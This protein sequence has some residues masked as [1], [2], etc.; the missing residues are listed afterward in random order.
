MFTADKYEC[1]DSQI[2]DEYRNEA[3]VIVQSISGPI[4]DN[5][6]VPYFKL[7]KGTILGD[8]ILLK[9]ARTFYEHNALWDLAISCLDE[10]IRLALDNDKRQ[11]ALPLI[12]LVR[13]YAIKLDDYDFANEIEEK[14]LKKRLLMENTR[15]TNELRR[16]QEYCRVLERENARILD[17]R[18]ETSER[19]AEVESLLLSNNLLVSELKESETLLERKAAE[20]EKEIA[21]LRECLQL[22]RANGIDLQSV[23]AYPEILPQC[24][25]RNHRDSL[26]YIRR[27]IQSR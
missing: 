5:S 8:V 24:W 15:L 17:E 22:S 6:T 7:V 19:M 26:P 23:I 2:A 1:L 12:R 20:Q 11:E 27:Y 14:N 13:E 21:S 3:R 18:N 10:E 25:L 9:Q 16:V 4:S